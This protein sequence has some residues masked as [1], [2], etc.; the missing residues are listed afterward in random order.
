VLIL[1]SHWRVL[2]FS[3]AEVFELLEP[4]GMP[5]STLIFRT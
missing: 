4:L 5:S 3:T 1:K 2:N